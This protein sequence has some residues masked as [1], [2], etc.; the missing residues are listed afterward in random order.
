[1]VAGVLCL[2][3]FASRASVKTKQEE[4][5]AVPFS[6]PYIVWFGCLGIESLDKDG[7]CENDS[8]GKEGVTLTVRSLGRKA[9]SVHYPE[10][11]DEFKHKTTNF[12]CADTRGGVGDCFF[13][14]TDSEFGLYFDTST[15]PFKEMP[16]SGRHVALMDYLGIG[17]FRGL[18]DTTISIDYEVPC[19]ETSNGAVGQLSIIVYVRHFL[20]GKTFALN[21]LLF[22][23]RGDYTTVLMHDGDVPFVSASLTPGEHYFTMPERSEHYTSVP[24]I[25]MKRVMFSLTRD[26]W[27]VNIDAINRFAK[28]HRE[29][30]YCA[31]DFSTNLFEYE[32]TGFGVLNEIAQVN[33]ET[34]N[35]KM[36]C[37]FK[38]FR[39]GKTLTQA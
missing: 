7:Y 32:I 15:I 20:T 4:G 19:F 24:D 23:N 31:E 3:G 11:V 22:D 2:T 16:G 6:A 21:Y 37:H 8:F 26:N 30:N 18:A 34:S 13:Q 29:K 27:M 1:M 33:G 10:L 25:G 36:G 28:D 17:R 39:Y 12:N 5:T 38:N 35:A 14:A 9:L